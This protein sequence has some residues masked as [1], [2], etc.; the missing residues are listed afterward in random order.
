[1]PAK[2][3]KKSEEEDEIEEVPETVQEECAKMITELAQCRY[4]LFETG[5]RH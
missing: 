3:A 4:T 5:I 2:K 1:M